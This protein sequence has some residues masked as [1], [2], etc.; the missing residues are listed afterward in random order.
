MPD[1]FLVIRIHPDS[2]F[3][4]PNLA[5]TWRPAGYV[6]LEGRAA[7]QKASSLS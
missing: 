1:N 7:P 6:M 4:G 2:P 5:C 3:D